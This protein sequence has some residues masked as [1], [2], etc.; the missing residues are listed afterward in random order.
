MNI[1]KAVGIFTAGIPIVGILI[2]GITFGINFKTDVQ[3]IKEDVAQQAEVNAEVSEWFSSIP[4]TY[5][6]SLVWSAIDNINIPDEYDDSYLDERVQ[7]LALQVTELRTELDNLDIQNVES[8]DD[9]ILRGRIAE[10]EGSLQALSNIEV[11]TDGKVDISPL[12]VRTASLEGGLDGVKA[13]LDTIREDIRSMKSDIKTNERAAS[14][15]TNTSRPYDDS[16]LRTRISAVERQVYSLPTTSSSGSTIQRVENPF[17]DSSLRSDISRLQTAVAVLEAAP[18]NAYDDSNLR[19]MI[20]DIQW[21][22]DNIDIPAPANNTTDV[23]WLEDLIY[24]VKQELSWRIDELEHAATSITGD[25][26]TYAEKWMLEDLQYEVMTIQE[27]VWE[28]QE[29][30][31][32]YTDNNNNYNN[33]GTTSSNT[34]TGRSWDGSWNEPY[35]IQVNH[36]DNSTNHSYT[37]DYWMDGYWNGEAVWTNWNCGIP[38]WD[39]CHIYKYNHTSWVL[40]PSEPGNEW[41]ANSYNDNGEWPWEGNWDGDVISVQNMD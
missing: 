1:S 10:L 13:S 6:D 20:D 18:N 9:T 19:N 22:L 30:A 21:E 36:K 14:S 8:F 24:E 26:D 37:G 7:N 23:T 15:N 4:D 33:D 32:N 29:I 11:G 25:D 35:W 38:P 5:D 17:D 28:L 2:G 41:L 27:Q 3:N 34:T 39:I 16:D 40:Q 12:I 31:N